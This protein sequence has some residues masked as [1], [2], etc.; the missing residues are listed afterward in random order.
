MTAVIKASA[1]CLTLVS[2]A[3]L[4]PCSEAQANDLGVRGQV[5]E[6]RETDLLVYIK[7]KAVEFEKSGKLAAWQNDAQ[8]RART[9]V[10]TPNPVSGITNATIERSRLFDPSITVRKDILD[11]QSRVIAKAGTSVN[12]LDYLPLTT[13]MTFINGNDPAQVNWAFGVET[14]NKIILTSGPIASLMREHKRA[15]YFDQ[16]GLI[17]DRFGIT[18]V[19]ATVT[20]EGR[21]L[22]IRE[23]PLRG[24][25]AQ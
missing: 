15:L 17:T 22:R 5:W 10:E 11:H 19:P 2:L 16:K 25:I 14:K 3:A 9:Y 23:F 20:Q 4:L 13:S 21:A 8:T 7:G 24:E 12:P 1:L 18:T 6:I